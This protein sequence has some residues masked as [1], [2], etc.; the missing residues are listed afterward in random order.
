MTAF[1]S[2]ACGEVYKITPKGT[3]NVLLNFDCISGID[4]N[5]PLVLGTNGNFYGTTQLGGGGGSQ[6]L[7]DVFEISPSG[8]TY[9]ILHNF[10]EQDGRTPEGALVQ[11][12]DGNFYGTTLLGG[13]F[14]GGVVFLISPD[15][16]TFRTL[17]NFGENGGTAAQPTGLVLGSDGNLYGATNGSIFEITPAGVL[18]TLHTFERNEVAGVVTLMQHTNGTFYGTTSQ[19]GANNNCPPSNG[20]G[21]VFSLSTGLGPFVTAVPPRRGI[22]ARVLLLG[23]GFTGATSVTFNGVPATFSVN[24]DTEITTFPVGATKGYI[25]VT[26]PKGTLSTKVIFIV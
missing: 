8:G 17:Y 14:D 19:S 22:G 20:C 16:R 10:N 26:T 2:S 18:T 1:A 23:Q 24:S 11:G 4:P 12:A 25:H 15:G 9:T 21:T 3:F 5:D 13:A 7:G 6:A